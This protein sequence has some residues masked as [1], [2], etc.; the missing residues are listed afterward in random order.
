MSCIHEM[1]TKISNWLIFNATPCN[2]SALWRRPYRYCDQRSKPMGYDDTHSTKL[3]NLT[4]RSSWWSR[5][6][7]LGTYSNHTHTSL[8]GQKMGAVIYLFTT[9][10]LEQNFLK[11]DVC[12]AKLFL[13]NTFSSSLTYQLSC[14]WSWGFSTSGNHRRMSER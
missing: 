6:W 5:P 14:L 9:T 10:F 11:C 8:P 2:I 13:C 7:A 4:T 12:T 1:Y 3:P